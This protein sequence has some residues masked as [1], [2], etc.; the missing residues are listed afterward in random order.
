MP[1]LSKAS[2]LATPT[3]AVLC[4]DN[5]PSIWFSTHRDVCPTGPTMD[6][7]RAR[8]IDYASKIKAADPS[9][10][11]VGPEEWGWSGYFWS[12]YDQQWGAANNWR[13]P[14]PDQSAHGGMDYM[15]WLLSQLYQYQQT[16]GTRVLDVFSLHFYVS[17]GTSN[18]QVMLRQ[19][20]LRHMT[21]ATAACLPR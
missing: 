7:I 1:A 18:T 9:A 4:Q 13:W 14:Y 6:D 12:G 3:H 17:M 11:I 5:E 21:A 20:T 15:P 19:P 2:P 10:Q 8:I 16:T